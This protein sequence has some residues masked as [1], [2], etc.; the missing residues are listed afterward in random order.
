[1]SVKK[2]NKPCFS[3]GLNE[4]LT[5]IQQAENDYKWN[6]SEVNRLDKLTQDY[7]HELELGN[8]NY[9]ERAKTA[10]KIAKCRQERRVS[11]DTVEALAP[12]MQFLESEKG[13]QMLNLLKEVLGKTRKAEKFMENRVY[14]YKVLD[15]EDLS[16]EN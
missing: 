8:L 11:K 2:N 13:K 9:S 5:I 15:K 10:T 14:R 7:L 16:L 4:F 6:E 1:M 3:Q 12:L